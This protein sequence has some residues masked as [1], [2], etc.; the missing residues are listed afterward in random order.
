MP[1]ATYKHADGELHLTAAAAKTPGDVEVVG[2]RIGVVSGCSPIEIGDMYTLQMKGVFTMSA[3]GTDI[4][5]DG[6]ILY[7]DATDGLTDEAS[8]NLQCGVAV[9]AKADS[10]HTA[11]VDINVFPPA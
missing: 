5:A 11:A 6:A 10:V 9:G 2:T 1:T 4:W 3:L 8:G 7:Y